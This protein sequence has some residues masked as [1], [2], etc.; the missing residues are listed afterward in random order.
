HFFV[1]FLILL[2]QDI[3]RNLAVMIPVGA[4]AWLMHYIDMT[5]NVMPVIHPEGLH[6]TLWDP[7]L[8]FGMSALLGRLFWSEYRKN[9]PYPLKDPRLLE[10]ILHHEVPAPAASAANAAH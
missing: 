9:P 5:Y 8:W 3:K 10:A 7:L 2:N 6:L 4:W 1:P